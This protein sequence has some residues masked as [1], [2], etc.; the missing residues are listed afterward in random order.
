MSKRSLLLIFL[1]TLSIF[2]IHYFFTDTQSPTIDK[3]GKSPTLYSRSQEKLTKDQIEAKTA[4]LSSFPIVEFFSNEQASIYVGSGIKS[5]NCFFIY[6]SELNQDVKETLPEELYVKDNTSSEGIALIKK[7]LDSPHTFVPSMYCL[8]GQTPE[9]YSFFLPEASHYDVQL[10]VFDH[11]DKA[12]YVYPAY[13]ENNF[14]QFYGEPLRENAI[15]MAQLDNRYYPVGFYDPTNSFF[16]SLSHIPDYSK[17]VTFKPYKSKLPSVTREK[18]YV[19]ENDYQQIAFSNLGGAIAEINLPF[20]SESDPLS[21][22]LP[23]QFD[24]IIEKKYPQNSFFPIQSY[25]SYHSNKL[26]NPKNG[27]YYPLIRRD[28]ESAQG[29]ASF[30]TPPRLYSLNLVADD[31]TD[32]AKAPYNVTRFEKDLI[33]FE[34]V[35]P[36]RRIKKTF[37]FIKNNNAFVPYTL[38]LD[39]KIEGDSKGLHITSGVPEVELISGSAAPDLKYRYSRNQKS[40]VEKIKLPKK[41]T[42]IKGVYPD[43]VSNSNGFFGLILDPISE[44]A[45]GLDAE[46]IAGKTD[47]TRL[48]LIDATHELYPE[49]KYP[50]YLIQLPL[51]ATSKTSSFTLF[52][53]PYD[54]DILNAVDKALANSETGY[55]PKYSEAQSFHGWFSFISEPFAKFLM[56]LM[57]FFY[58]FTQSWAFSIVLITIVLRI[59]LY[60]LNSWS[61]KSMTKM[62]ML[63]PEVEKIK[64]R[65]AKDPKRVQLET[66]QLYKA[67][68]A[69]PFS[70]C[71]PLIIQ[72]PFLIGMFDLLKSAFQLRGCS[73]IPGWINNL[74]A[75]DVLFSWSYPIFF[76]GTQFHLLP[77]IL[78][79]MM[80]LQQK[81]TAWTSKNKQTD[82]NAQK[83]TAISGN[84]MTIVFTLMFYNFPSGLNIYWISST[85]LGILQQFLT[86]RQLSKASLPKKA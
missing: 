20:K 28:L 3:S 86:S 32:L 9:F 77:F 21:V 35:Q 74:A 38:K 2:F 55:S 70:G 56:I 73:F 84:L 63:A 27:G 53:G 60:P 16:L 71:L 61:I 41:T 43:W 4:K 58:S 79:A 67:K 30:V 62:Q 78:G 47:P 82:V 34:L 81:I 72:M 29:R 1:F 66:M 8:A 48:T 24:R 59:L 69:N 31:E 42:T 10:I 5:Q 76:F 33:E 14:I 37:Y 45:P 23:I 65:Y 49:D 68:G 15:V 50:G 22:V 18:Y 80:L 46:F 11:N 36:H 51:K 12:P 7:I 39:I 17:I 40:V 57:K 52:A 6:A 85:L 13:Y 54:Q 25:L 19:L 64:K 44:I 75:P 83:Q 26:Q